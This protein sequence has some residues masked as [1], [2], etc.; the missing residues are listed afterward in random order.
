MKQNQS[1][2]RR[3]SRVSLAH[4]PSSCQEALESELMSLERRCHQPW[5]SLLYNNHKP[6]SKKKYKHLKCL[7]K[8]MEFKKPSN[9]IM[10]KQN[11]VNILKCG[12]VFLNAHLQSTDLYLSKSTICYFWISIQSFAKAAAFQC[13]SCVYIVINVCQGL[14]Q[15]RTT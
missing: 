1:F 9:S 11:T 8:R 7:N 15:E 14:W 12:L 3:Q 2:S 4:Q 10:L 5:Y 13:Y 6:T